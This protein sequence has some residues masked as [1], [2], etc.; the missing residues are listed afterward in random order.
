ML[1]ENCKLFDGRWIKKGSIYVEDGIFAKIGKCE[2]LRGK[3]SKEEAIDLKQKLV[4]PGLICAHT[5]AYSA[6]AFAFPV[7]GKSKDL[8][9]ILRKLW[10]PLDQCL[11]RE[12]VYWSAVLTSIRYLRNGVT[13]IID[14]HASPNALTGSLSTLAEGFREVGI[15]SCLSY[16]VT[17]RYGENKAEEAIRENEGFIKEYGGSRKDEL[18]S[19]LFGLHASFTLG[20]E[21]LKKCSKTARKLDAGFHL[22]LAE[23]KVDV[24]D[25]LSRFKKP[26]VQHLKDE[27]ILNE[28]T[29]A[30]HCVNLSQKDIKTLRETKAKVITNPRSNA[31]NGI[32]VMPLNNILQEGITIGIGNDGLGYD[33]LEE[34]KALQ[35]MHSLKTKRPSVL[36]SKVLNEILFLNNS[37][38]AKNLFK[39][40]VGQISKGAYAD[41]VIMDVRPFAN[42]LN[43]M[44]LDSSLI[45]SVMVGGKWIIKNRKFLNDLE[46]YEGGIKKTAERIREKA[47]E[48]KRRKS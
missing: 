17:D 22:H 39:K 13:T 30:A 20:S 31:N 29:L 40:G 15:R 16:E 7:K 42:N 3:Y 48:I 10:W 47:L 26:L 45:D 2:E 1:L 43:L 28:K 46:K 12:G 36:P 34:V 8:K 6:F 18:I 23:G 38:I 41:L 9:G 4:L 21:S 44:N 27:D 19:A 32:G 37:K 5:H 33:M 14:H 25:A 11:D 35:L 24:I